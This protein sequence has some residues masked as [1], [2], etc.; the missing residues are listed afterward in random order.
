MSRKQKLRYLL[1]IYLV[2]A[3][4]ATILM[5]LA[6][7]QSNDIWQALFLNLSTE[8]LGVVLVFFLVNVVFVVSEWDLS[9]Q[10]AMLIQKFSNPSAR[11]FFKP[12]PSPTDIQGYI[13][14]AKSV[15]MCGVTLT[16]TINRTFSELRQRLFDGAS[17]RIIII[18]PK[19]ETLQEAALRSESGSV[20]HYKNRLDATLTE[21]T[22]LYKN[23]S[24]RKNAQGDKV[25]NLSIGLLP[26]TPSFGLLG[27]QFVDGGRLVIVEMYPHHVGYDEPPY[28]FLTPENDVEWFEYF[29][30]QFDELWKRTT[31]WVP[32]ESTES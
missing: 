18:A 26:Y 32:T 1:A 25:G 22:Y 30:T 20:E 11:D 15:D 13:Q 23:W 10:V 3:L 14:K 2:I 9:E 24:E 27:F 28:F 5:V 16:T 21:L 7:E 12:A 19:P 4:L 31:K 6:F 17:V 8:L 29:S